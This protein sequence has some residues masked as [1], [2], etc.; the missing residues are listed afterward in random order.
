ML[1]LSI[2]VAAVA[3]FEAFALDLYTE[4]FNIREYYIAKG[5]AAANFQYVNEDVFV[6]G[7]RPGGRYLPFPFEIH[8]VSSVFLEPVSIGFYAF[9]SGLYFVAMKDRLPRAQVFLA[10]IATLLLIWLGDARMAFAS[11]ML[12]LLCRPL[13]GY[14]DHRLSIFIFPAALLFLVFVVKSG[15][16]NLSGEGV[17]ARFL[18]TYEWLQATEASQF[19]GLKPYAAEMVDSGFLYLLSYQGFWGFLLFWLPPILYG[20]RFSREARIY[21]F[22]ASIFLTFGLLISNAIFTIKTAAL[23]WFGFGYII[24]RTR[25]WTNTCSSHVALR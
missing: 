19:F 12:V 6:S 20:R 17:G 2:L 5:Y 15:I 22:G 23:L 3:I 16:F 9:I 21:W 14:L 10:I 11:L 18:W 24:A 25:N 1:W 13:F 8:R 4:L 7:I